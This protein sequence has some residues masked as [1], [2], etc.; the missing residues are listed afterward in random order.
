MQS[1]EHGYM[2][3]ERANLERLLQSGL[4][5][6]FR[7]LNPTTRSYTWWSNRLN[8]R[9]VNRGW[10]LDYFIVSAELLGSVTAI[11]HLRDIQGSEHCPIMLEFNL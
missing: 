8:R 6:V 3:D 2:T 11:E 5:D 1:K 7:E 10:R 9:K 4:A